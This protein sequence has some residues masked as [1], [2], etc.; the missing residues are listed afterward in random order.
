MGG[1]ADLVVRPEALT[2]HARS[3]DTAAM[4]VEQAIAAGEHVCL[5][6]NTYGLLG[7]SI[8]PLIDQVQ[9]S[10]VSAGKV[11]AGALRSAGDLLRRTA[12]RYQ[13]YEDAVEAQ[14]RGLATGAA[15]PATATS[16][17][18]APRHDTTD[19]WSG[20]S[21]AEDVGGL[22]TRLRS[23]D[24]IAAAAGVPGAGIG[25]LGFVVNPVGQLA[26]WAPAWT[27]EHS[28]SLSDAL[29]VLAGD[30][31]QIT[32]HEQTWHNVAGSIRTTRADLH[33]AVEQESAEWTG[34]A[35]T[36]FRQHAGQQCAALGALAIAADALADIVHET[37]VLVASVRQRVR[38]LLAEFVSVLYQRLWQWLSQEVTTLGL[39]T[40]RIV[41]EFCSLVASTMQQ[42]RQVLIG[43]DASL[44]R[45]APMVRRLEESITLLTNLWNRLD[46][47][48]L[49][50]STGDT[51]P[52]DSTS[53]AERERAERL[54]RWAEAAPIS[55]LQ[56][57][58]D[59]LRER[60]TRETWPGDQRDLATVAPILAGRQQQ[61]FEEWA[62][63]ASTEELQRAK[64]QGTYPRIA[65]GILR[66][67]DDAEYFLKQLG[68]RDGH[69]FVLDRLEEMYDRGASIADLKQI[70][71]QLWHL[72]KSSLQEELALGVSHFLE[73]KAEREASFATS[74]DNVERRSTEH[75]ASSMSNKDLAGELRAL[76]DK[77][78]RGE[79]TAEDLV[80]LQH[81]S[82]LMHERHTKAVTDWL[83]RL[84]D[85]DLARVVEVL[86][87]RAED[88]GRAE[89][90]Q[91]LSLAKEEQRVR[92]ANKGLD[93]R[94][95][96]QDGRIGTIRDLAMEAYRA[97]VRAGLGALTD[98]IASSVTFMA[99]GDA[100]LARAVGQVFDGFGDMAEGRNRWHAAHAGASGVGY[101]DITRAAETANDPSGYRSTGPDAPHV[102][103]E[104]AL[105]H[106]GPLPHDETV[107][108]DPGEPYR[109]PE[110]D[111][112]DP[113]PSRLD[114]YMRG[115]DFNEAEKDTYA[116]RE[117][118]L[119]SG[120]VVDGY[121]PGSEIVFRRSTQFAELSPEYAERYVNEFLDKYGPGNVVA[122]TPTMR[123]RY[124]DLVGKPLQGDL[125][126][127]VPIQKAPVPEWLGE[128]TRRWNITIR[129]PT[130]HVYNPD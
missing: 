26:G 116:A 99:T 83:D 58:V 123:E 65:D 98:N 42:V 109:I 78:E 2:T 38:N 79:A 127:E 69:K 41:S 37:G 57:F 33:A 74:G 92:E 25:I 5:N 52:G 45:L 28:Q 129:D 16:P 27:M 59:D 81:G 91:Y 64:E 110:L 85:N 130:G 122:D 75:W 125:I 55:E 23:G 94:V 51:L 73:Q 96:N 126:L 121:N 84:S 47:G 54:A 36:A 86:D 1:E 90:A 21:I 111:S 103:Y 62:K 4:A 61:A 77:A 17:L 101:D 8:P 124:P 29:D 31:D 113:R 35:A 105:D 114:N 30:P 40:P 115:N 128:W 67:R 100:N 12:A 119:E 88:T 80:H 56:A 106:A 48:S 19:A 118:R 6:T 50:T 9:R 15:V 34:T 60:A 39:A 11:A 70:E 68:T 53:P 72:S 18:V 87:V 112:Q 66:A 3:F 120:K 43:L 93:T 13:G 107:A 71:G 44:E 14:F 104:D 20:I 82:D 24:W 89:D 49:T 63:T 7:Q 95:I 108:R 32:A 102:R 22:R 117:V 76:A 10:A 97:S 46:R